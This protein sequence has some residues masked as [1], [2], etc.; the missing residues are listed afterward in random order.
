MKKFIYWSLNFYVW[1]YGDDMDKMFP[2]LKKKKKKVR[3]YCT[4]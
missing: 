2:I 3:Q 4:L 1:T